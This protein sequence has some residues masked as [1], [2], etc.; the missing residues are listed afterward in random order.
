MHS[1]ILKRYN[2]IIIKSQKGAIDIAVAVVLVLALLVIAIIAFFVW[3]NRSKTISVSPEDL[4]VFELGDEH[5]DVVYKITQFITGQTGLTAVQQE[6]A[7]VSWRVPVGSDPTAADYVT[8][9][10]PGASGRRFEIDISAD[11]TK[12]ALK[13]AIGTLEKGF[14]VAPL[15]VKAF[16]YNHFTSDSLNT[17]TDKDALDGPVEV[18]SFINE[19]VRC[20]ITEPAEEIEINHLIVAISCVDQNNFEKRYGEQFPIL[21]DLFKQDYPKGFWRNGA[22]M[23]PGIARLD[24]FLSIS[25][26]G[27]YNVLEFK[28]GRYTWLFGGQDTAPCETVDKFKVPKE[29]YGNCYL[30]SGENDYKERFTDEEV[31]SHYL[32]YPND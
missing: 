9:N 15:A 6:S 12:S 2:K 19:K 17:Y 26:Q 7:W 4:P 22:S 1:S 16:E 31:K 21:D 8:I 30:G 32:D 23:H 24:N 11:F 13:T 25:A 3:S 29:I 10:I 20:S 14:G 28:D 27:G 18:Q 5:Y